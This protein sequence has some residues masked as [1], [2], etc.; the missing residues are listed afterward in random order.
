MLNIKLSR[1]SI[2]NVSRYR[3]PNPRFYDR[4]ASAHP[5]WPTGLIFQRFLIANKLNVI[6]I[7]TS[8]KENRKETN[9]EPVFCFSN[10]LR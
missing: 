1:K 5:T 6:R 8:L 3:D 4:K 2:L 7:A 9:G 10:E